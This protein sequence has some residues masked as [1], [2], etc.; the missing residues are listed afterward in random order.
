MKD[1]A[2]L[3]LRIC[4]MSSELQA[5]K[6]IEPKLRFPEF[7]GTGGWEVKSIGDKKFATLYKGKGISKS[8]IVQGGKTPCIR[9][10]ELYTC[11]GEIIYS[12]ISRTNRSES[13]LFLSKK[14]D[15]IIP[16][17][18]ETKIDIATASCVKLDNVALGSDLSVIRTQHNGIFLSYYLNSAL[19]H[20]IAKI[21]QGDSVVHLYLSQLSKICLLVPS[22]KEQQR[23]ADCLSSLDELIE[24]QSQELDALR[25]HKKGLMQQLFPAEGET[26]P[27]HRFPEFKDA[28]RWEEMNGY[29]L[30]VQISNRK[31]SSDLPILAITQEYGAIPRDKIDYRVSVT[32]KSVESYKVVEVSD[33]IISLRSFQGGIEYSNYKGLCSPAYVVLRRK[34]DDHKI[35]FKYYFKTNKFI[36]D[37]NKDIAGIRDGKMVSY[38][39]FLNLLLVLPELKEEQQRIADCLSSLDELIE[40]QSKKLDALRTHKKGLMQQLFPT[41]SEVQE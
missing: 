35:F 30:F 41:I 23:I 22:L 36:N 29:K 8:D 6:T 2:N 4:K 9:Y 21:A 7:K 40:A 11:Y 18:G 1:I 37:L 33:F 31:H 24:A 25:T 17:S 16:S 3:E 32:D 19:K 10:G 27:K 38:S 12:V 28:G 13:E 14:N 15:V 5:K 34:R 39:Q 26:M 20:E